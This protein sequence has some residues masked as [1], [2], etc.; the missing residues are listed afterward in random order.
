MA[1]FKRIKLEDVSAFGTVRAVV[2]IKLEK[3]GTIGERNKDLIGIEALIFSRLVGS[4][5][6]HF[7][8]VKLEVAQP[9]VDFIIGEHD[10][11][12][13][14]EEKF[15]RSFA[16]TGSL[17]SFLYESITYDDNH[18]V[19]HGGKALGLLTIKKR[20]LGIKAE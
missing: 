5:T 13:S 3:I 1:N 19:I 14:V 4:G 18:T 15:A 6:G 17:Q 10:L 2:Y 11:D 8:H 16:Y 20:E 7:R 12:V 9:M